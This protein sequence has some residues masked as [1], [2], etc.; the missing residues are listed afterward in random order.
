LFTELSEHYQTFSAEVRPRWR[1]TRA[2]T[3]Y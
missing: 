2:I 1:H 3:S